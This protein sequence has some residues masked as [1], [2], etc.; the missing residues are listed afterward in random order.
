LFISFISFISSENGTK[1]KSIYVHDSLSEIM[2]MDTDMTTN[3]E[4]NEYY[5]GAFGD[6][7][8]Q[9]QV[10]PTTADAFR[11]STPNDFLRTNEEIN[12][13]EGRKRRVDC[14]DFL[15]KFDAQRR[16]FNNHITRH[17]STKDAATR[18]A[19]AKEATNVMPKDTQY[20]QGLN[21]ALIE[22]SRVANPDLAPPITSFET[23]PVSPHHSK[24]GVVLCATKKIKSLNIENAELKYQIDMLKI[25]ISGSTAHMKRQPSIF[26]RGWRR[27]KQTFTI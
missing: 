2:N 13:G 26:I 27:L 17:F 18:E 16:R 25:Q 21:E 3:E 24:K 9:P 8:T 10:P 23:N 1:T 11:P 12:S 4:W 6:L 19:A 22:L 15:Q 7:A 14:T 20:R 5:R